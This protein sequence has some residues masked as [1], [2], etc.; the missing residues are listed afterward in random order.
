MNAIPAKVAGVPRLVMATPA[1]AREGAQTINR[2]H[3]RPG[4]EINPLVL[5][6]AKRAGVDE[7]YRVGG[8]QAVAALAFGAGP[9]A[10]VDVIAGPGNAYVAEAKRQVFG[11]VGVDSVA[12]PSE[13]LVVA[14]GKTDPAWVAADLLSQAEHDPSSQSILITDDN[15]F[16]SRVE[17]CV[18]AQLAQSPRRDIAG[19]AWV[20]R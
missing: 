10:P 15:D 4:G 6:A 19:A 1:P 8:A 5:A 11:H 17:A 12:G 16:A 13:V 14:D 2:P 7:V 3:L 20:E 9:I 18:K